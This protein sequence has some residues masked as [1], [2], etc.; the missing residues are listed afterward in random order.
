MK[1]RFKVVAVGDGGCGK[2]SLLSSFSNNV[3]P[4]NYLPTV[5]ETFLKVFDY[6]NESYEIMLW[7]T[8]GQEDYDR[9]RPL[10]YQDTNVILCCFDIT[11]A[12][13]FSNVTEKWIP[14]VDP[15]TN[16]VGEGFLSEHK[17]DSC[18]HE[19]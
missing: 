13:S 8:A 1:T 11:D 19:E 12:D 4:E 15:K 18:G 17:S 7:D 10:S 5:F 16:F 3:F 2:T 6:E 14:E 9:L